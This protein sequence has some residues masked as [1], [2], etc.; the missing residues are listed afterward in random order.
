[1]PTLS[2]VGDE[3]TP[4]G[5]C[6]LL[7][8]HD[9]SK[10]TAGLTLEMNV[11]DANRAYLEVYFDRLELDANVAVTLADADRGTERTSFASRFREW[12]GV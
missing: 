2:V 5:Y 11:G 4:T 3:P 6:V 8:G 9:V 12:V 1:M 10:F 7:D